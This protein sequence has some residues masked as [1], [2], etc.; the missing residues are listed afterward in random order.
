MELTQQNLTAHKIS[1]MA[2]AAGVGAALVIVTMPHVYLESVI[3]ASGL[4]EILPAAAPPLG[5]TARGL[6]AIMAG[7]VS[8]SAIYFFLN[9]KGSSDMGVALREQINAANPVE[10]ESEETASA[11]KSRFALPKFDAK[12]LT[13]F[14]KKPKK[15]KARVMDLADLPQLRKLDDEEEAARPSIFS[16]AE[17]NS[18]MPE[19]IQPFEEEAAGEPMAVEEAAQDITPEPAE[20]VA[21]D[22]QPAEPAPMEPETVS[23]PAP[24]I[25][26]PKI[27]VPAEDLSDLNIAQLAERL[28]AGLSRLKQLEGIGTGTTDIA[29]KPATAAS[30]HSE[31]PANDQVREAPAFAPTPLREVGQPAASALDERQA[32]MDV[33]LKAALGTLEK[34]TAQR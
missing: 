31:A 21:D 10:L 33:A 28:E 3:G 5:N 34:M 23:V 4:S 2:V 32:D 8:A 16:V 30:Q 15:D 18:T 6:I 7:L 25:P 27:T 17:A 14:L 9:R 26:A 1:V 29:S 24:D 19:T 13:K 12:S 20:S 11:K 22:E